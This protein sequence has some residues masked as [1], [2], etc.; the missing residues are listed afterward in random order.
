MRQEQG[1]ASGQAGTEE[2]AGAFLEAIPATFPNLRAAT[3]LVLRRGY[4][5]AGDFDSGLE[6][7]LDGLERGLA[8]R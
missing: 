2:A 6:L 1:A 3:E 7:I 8:S 4:D 5:Q